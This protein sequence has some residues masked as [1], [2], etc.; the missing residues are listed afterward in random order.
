[1]SRDTIEQLAGQILVAGFQNHEPDPTLYDRIASGSLGGI[2]W[3]ARNIESIEQVR[4]VNIT[5]QR[6]NTA[7]APL[8][9]SV[10]QEGG[11]VRRFKKDVIELPPMQTIG[12]LDQPELTE[13]LATQLAQ[14]LLALGFNADFAPVVDIHTNPD[15]PVIGDRAFGTDANTVIKHAQHFVNGMQNAGMAACAKHFPG[16]GDTSQ[17]SHLTLPRCEL[18]Q[19]RLSSV[20]LAPFRALSPSIASMMSAHVVYPAVDPQNPATL[21]PKWIT[22]ILRNELGYQGVIFSD[23]L[24]M[25][26][27]AAHHAPGAAAC[28]AVAA[29][30]DALLICSSADMLNE[31]HSAL[32]SKAQNDIPFLARLKNAVSRFEK[33]RR[34]YP[35]IT[36]NENA[37]IFTSQILEKRA[38]L[39]TKLKNALD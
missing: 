17:D 31:V 5:M 16:H 19:E 1:M 11:R 29:G 10:D 22:D 14:E 7:Q 37:P 28:Q 8:F 2:I 9:I 34:R 4:R 38:T 13:A 30:C 6:R 39:A 24:E 35:G 21:S 36:L 12:A 3:F 33:M 27:I 26:A 18:S 25:R 20:E 32:V 23:D 15:N